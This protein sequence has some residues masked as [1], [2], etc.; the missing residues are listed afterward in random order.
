M[1]LQQNVVYNSDIMLCSGKIILRPK[2]SYFCNITTES[3]TGKIYVSERFHT[4]VS[5]GSVTPARK[6]SVGSMMPREQ[7]P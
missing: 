5:A 2:A 6:Y 7:V 3:F 1:I 4:V